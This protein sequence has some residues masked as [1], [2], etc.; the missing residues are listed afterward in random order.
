[1]DEK[2]PLVAGDNWRHPG[3]GREKRRGTWRI[4]LYLACAT[5]GAVTYLRPASRQVSTSSRDIEIRYAGEKISWTSCGTVANR[6]LECSSIDVPMDQFNETN[7]GDKTF[8]VPLVRLRGRN[9]TKNILLNPGGPGGSGTEFVFRR[10]ESLSEIVGEE[11]HLL[12][13]DPR[14]INGSRPLASCYPDD[15]TRQK[16]QTVR[17]DKIPEDSGELYAWT[18]NSVKACAENAGEHGAY[19]N[20][21]QTAA[22]MNSILDA[23]GQ[24]D[25]LYWGFS[26]GTLLGQTYA[27]L[28][29]ERSK[30]VIIDG[31]ANQFDWYE[32]KLDTE[33]FEDSYNVFR[34]FLDECYKAK[35][36]CSLSALAD[37]KEELEKKLL[38]AIE[39]LRDEPLGVY[40]NS[41]TYGLLQYSDVWYS[42]IF[43]ALYK[44]T[45][46]Y[47]LADH[48]AAL[49]Q[50]NGTAAFLAYHD[51]GS[52]AK[53]TSD[54]NKFVTLNDGA[55]GPTYWQ[56][57]RKDLLDF[58][59]PYFGQFQFSESEFTTY[60]A[61]QLWSIPKSHGYVP[62]RGVQTAHP[63]LV[64]STTF[65]PI[66][67]LVSARSA[68]DTFEG[69]RLVE[70][71][72]YGHCSIAMPS[73]CL[74]RHVRAYLLDGSLPD[75]GTQCEIDAPYFVKPRE[76]GTVVATL[77]LTDPEEQKIH[78][79]QL[80][81]A[82]NSWF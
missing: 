35:D 19:I 64:L 75:E 32:A 78:L 29:P 7:S 41:T 79:A 70:V 47:E 15:A 10:G 45:K 14:G 2:L 57:D 36:N 51:D 68:V 5:L 60:F 53:N 52:I 69:S 77:E 56:G 25:M 20:T 1:M 12:S 22:D 26:Y 54:A 30:R 13:F 27:T 59:L 34:G 72:G 63:L 9:A 76:D 74:A 37:N 43:S 39:K 58:L 11:F 3:R 65:D 28:F 18:Q 73:M 33:A 8:S 40:V 55:S 31:V 46:W 71:L 38:P 62:R 49:L 4:A 50:G 48:L 67:P 44:P 82:T 42:G 61:K 81:L 66:C 80:D 16:L 21:P 6:P 17:Q 24:T 23:V